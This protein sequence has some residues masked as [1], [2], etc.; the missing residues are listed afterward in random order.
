ML[1]IK[2]RN[3]G[4]VDP[5][6]PTSGDEKE[7]RPDIDHNYGLLFRRHQAAVLDDPA[8]RPDKTGSR[9]C[10][11]SAVLGSAAAG[12]VGRIDVPS[13]PDAIITEVTLSNRHEN[14]GPRPRDCP[15]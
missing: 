15:F 2:T 1:R 8:V 11:L 5:I 9:V 4:K 3:S 13:I 12:K 6:R 10:P 7:S 14:P